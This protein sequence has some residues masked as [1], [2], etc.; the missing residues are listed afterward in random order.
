MEDF[1][2]F[3]EYEDEDYEDYEF[4]PGYDLVVSG[5]CSPETDQALLQTRD[6]PVDHTQDGPEHVQQEDLHQFLPSTSPSLC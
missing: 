6:C 4:D 3:Y 5:L 1:I 2:Y